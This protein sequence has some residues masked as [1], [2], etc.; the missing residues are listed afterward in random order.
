MNTLSEYLHAKHLE[1]CNRQG[2]IIAE[3]EWVMDVLNR[4]LPPSDKLSNGSVN[5]WMNGGRNPDSKN[6]YRLFQVFGPEI[7]PIL[8]F[9]FTGLLGDIINDWDILPLEMQQEFH[10][11][12]K[13]YK[14]EYVNLQV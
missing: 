12:I 1:Y 5:Q 3:S 10:D 9:D 8:G 7:M 6:V 11:K 13:E 14:K 2:R 4:D